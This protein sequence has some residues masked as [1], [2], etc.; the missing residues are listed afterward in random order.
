MGSPSTP[1]PPPPPAPPPEEQT[2]DKLIRERDEKRNQSR[3]STAEES[4]LAGLDESDAFFRNKNL[5]QPPNLF[6]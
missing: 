6:Q 3:Q 4:L 2:R 5:G 1:S